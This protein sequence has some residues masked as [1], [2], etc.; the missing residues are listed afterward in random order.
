MKK[1]ALS[2]CALAA[3]AMV[4][5]GSDTSTTTPDAGV[6]PDAG[7]PDAGTAGF[8]KPAGTV[9][10]NFKADDSAN[11]VYGA[12]DLEWKGA[13]KYD[14]TTRMI[15]KDSSWGGP[16]AKLYDDGPWDK[17]GHEPAGSVA[18]DKKW[19]VTIFVTP[20][21][22]GSDT[23]SYGLNDANACTTDPAI[24][25][26]NGWSWLGD[27]GS[28]SVAAGATADVNA[29]GRTF[30]KFGTTDLQLKATKSGLLSTCQLTA[31]ATCTDDAS[32][33][34]AN[35]FC[36][37]ASKKCALKQTT[38]CTTAGPACPTG[39]SCIAPD[40]SKVTIK[41]SA[42]GWSEVKLADDGSGNFVYTQSAFTGAGKPLPHSGL[43]NT[44]DK[45]EF[46]WVF[47]GSEYRDR[48][49]TGSPSAIPGITASTKASG[50]SSFTAQTI[51]TTAGG[52]TTITVP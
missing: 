12:N 23:Y 18:G 41:S 30:A 17:G 48:T 43:L 45:P 10:V 28:F 34:D 37:G 46:V 42:W 1:L 50:A 22:T 25:S 20:P 11:G 2:I 7:T 3:T 47:N 31:P 35:L 36:N 21:A 39:Q 52:N 44:G 49:K 32:C 24:A 4:G 14:P 29:S 38:A 19:G 27:N 8:P 13:M 6:T 16:F 26:C 15:S 9:A 51:T 40:T 33:N 5:C